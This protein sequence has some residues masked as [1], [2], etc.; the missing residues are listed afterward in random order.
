MA[1][2]PGA[3][4]KPLLI[5]SSSRPQHERHGSVRKSPVRFRGTLRFGPMAEKMGQLWPCL[6]NSFQEAK[7]PMWPELKRFHTQL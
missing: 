7:E 3:M 6:L 5:P 2:R 4:E 1:Q